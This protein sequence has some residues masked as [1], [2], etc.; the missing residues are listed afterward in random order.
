MKNPYGNVLAGEMV[1][2][3]QLLENA[4]QGVYGYRVAFKS[5]DTYMLK[6]NI[7]EK[8]LTEAL[9]SGWLNSLRCQATT[10]NVYIGSMRQFA[11]E[12]KHLES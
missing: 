4:G 7:Q 11:A 3:L 12:K 10:K 1:A 8:A 9:L 6:N 2:F 5:L